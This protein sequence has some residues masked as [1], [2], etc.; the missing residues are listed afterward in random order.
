M[1][2]ANGRRNNK[3]TMSAKELA[4]ECKRPALLSAPNILNAVS[5]ILTPIPISQTPCAKTYPSSIGCAAHSTKPSRTTSSTRT[6]VSC[7]FSTCHPTTR[8][9]VLKTRRRTHPRTIFSKQ[10]MVRRT[11][12]IRASV[13]RPAS[14]RATACSAEQVVSEDPETLTRKQ[15]HDWIEELQDRGESKNDMQVLDVTRKYYDLKLGRSLVAVGS[16]MYWLSES[17]GWGFWKK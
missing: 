12:S 5:N 9:I 3:H 13:G 4:S 6:Q 11:E 17:F 10:R 7:S 16:S 1:E 15:L 2:P 14:I 8:R